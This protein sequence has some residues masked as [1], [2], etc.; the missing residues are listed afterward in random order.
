[1]EDGRELI[2]MVCT[3]YESPDS[4]ETENQHDFSKFILIWAS[5]SAI[6]PFRINQQIHP[7]VCGVAIVQNVTLIQYT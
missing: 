4:A 6:N 2:E 5:C 7:A 1:M 3:A